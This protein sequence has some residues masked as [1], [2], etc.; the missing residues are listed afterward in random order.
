MASSESG[1]V[2]PAT[3][4]RSVRWK[5]IITA[6]AVSATLLTT[7]FFY[8][9]QRRKLQRKKGKDLLSFDPGTS[10]GAGNN[11]I[12]ASKSQNSRKKNE[13]DLPWFSFASVSAATDN[14]SD[15]N[16]LGEGG[17]GP[18]YKISDFGMARIFGGN[19]SQATNRIVGTYGYMSPEYALKGLFSVKSD[20][21]SFGVLFLEI[22]TG[23]KNTSFYN[24]DSLT[25]LGYAWD[26]WKSQPNLTSSSRGSNVGRKLIIAALAVSM[27]LLTTA[28]FYSIRRRKLQKK[29]KDL[30]S[31][32]LGTSIGAGNTTLTKASKNPNTGKKEIDLPRF[33]FASVSAAT[34]N[35]SDANKLGE[36][37]FGPV[38]KDMTPKISDFGMA[39]IFGGNGSQATERI[40]GTYGYM[41]PEYALEGLFS[42]K[43]DVFSFG[44][45]LL[46]ILSGKRNTGFY[47]T[48]S[49]NLLGYTWDLWKSGRGQ[50]HIEL[51]SSLEG[52]I[53]GGGA[54]TCV[55][56]SALAL[57]TPL[58][59]SIFIQVMT[60]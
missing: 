25:L 56:S 39:R 49:L 17:F 51:S 47:H 46:E 44:V 34:D 4:G 5:W 58:P 43:S 32:D 35:F 55:N 26:L 38:Y 29:G 3:K 16:K 53:H 28:F 57:A 31:F 52:P 48:D 42:V 22:L 54:T 37:G 8:R 6:L 36:G 13:V 19:G 30:L 12:E 50:D 21:F 18:V 1:Y 33:S 10:I 59:I 45:L 41:S 23:K 60:R 7:A 2:N 27:T 24:S 40:V 20:V 11:T 14:F 9:I 15:A